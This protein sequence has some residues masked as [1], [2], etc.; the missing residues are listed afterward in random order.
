MIANPQMLR[1]FPLFCFLKTFHGGYFQCCDVLLTCCSFDGCACNACVLMST[2]LADNQTAEGALTAGRWWRFTASSLQTDLSV[3]SGAF[4]RLQKRKTTETSTTEIMPF[5]SPAERSQDKPSATW[6]LQCE[7]LFQM[8][9]PQKKKKLI[10]IGMFTG[11]F[12]ILVLCHRFWEMHNS[13]MKC[14]YENVFFNMHHKCCHLNAQTF[15]AIICIKVFMDTHLV[16]W[17]F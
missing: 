10:L 9:L 12:L 16:A 3:A 15:S 11:L 6:F 7:M 8:H 13:R 14:F 1:Y 17:L 2:T 5:I 4:G